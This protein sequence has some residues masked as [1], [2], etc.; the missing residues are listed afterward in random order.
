MKKLPTKSRLNL[1]I[2]ADLKK[3]AKE[4]ANKS[5]KSVTIIIC[6]YL[7]YLRDEEYREERELVEQI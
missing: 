7:K 5:G 2:E 6:E 3:W 1:N 4:Y